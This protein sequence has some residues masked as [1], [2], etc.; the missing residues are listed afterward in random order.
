MKDED[1]QAQEDA[2]F[3]QYLIDEGF[4]DAKEGED[5]ELRLYPIGYKSK[6]SF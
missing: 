3:M 2:N 4:I 5:G 6:K 1:T